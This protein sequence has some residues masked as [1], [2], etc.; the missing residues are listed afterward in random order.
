MKQWEDIVKDKL[1]GYESALPEGSLAAFRARASVMA[2]QSGHLPARRS[3]LLWLAAAAAACLAAVFFLLRQAPEADSPLVAQVVETP[4]EIVTQPQEPVRVVE[5]PRPAEKTKPAAVVE[6]VE[7]AETIEIVE[8]AETVE[9]VETVEPVETVETVETVEKTEHVEAIETAKV[10]EFADTEVVTRTA[11]SSGSYIA[12]GVAG[13]GL[14]AVYALAKGVSHFAP[15]AGKNDYQYDPGHVMDQGNSSVIPDNLLSQ[16]HSMPFKAG[17]SVRIKLNDRLGITTGLEYS[18]YT[19]RFKYRNSGTL[20]QKAQYLGVPLRL[21]WTFASARCFDF[22]VGGGLQ[23]DF[24][25]GAKL[26]GKSIAKDG[27]SFSMLGVG[28]VQLN[29]SK[30]IGIYMEPEFSWTKTAGRVLDTYRSKHPFMFSATAGLRLN[31]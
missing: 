9:E 8:L 25:V 21:D 19:S 2:G 24:C 29:I 26:G 27:F 17:L 5:T 30:R 15:A 6:T 1:E 18:L 14:A 28:G 4:K 16:K 20:T 12:G 11:N 10:V 31:L 13:G 3:P 23:G 22:Y 7:P